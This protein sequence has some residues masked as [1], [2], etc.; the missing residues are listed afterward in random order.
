MEPLLS[1][2]ADYDPDAA[3]V[4]PRYGAEC[5]R[6]ART[7]DVDAITRISAEREGLA[8]DTIRHRIDA[9]IGGAGMGDAWC[10]FVAEID[11]EVVAFG[12]VRYLT[13]AE[14]GLP[15]SLPEG[16]HLTGV[17]VTPRFRRRGLGAALTEARL[18]WLRGRAD[19]VFY[20][21]NLANRTSIALHAAFGFEEVAR[22]FDYPRAG[23]RAGEGAAFRLALAPRAG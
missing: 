13:H 12:R 4:G 7:D 16:W 10:V 21:S 20:V 1:H 19:E 8:P 17:V 11:A 2:I 9:E 14:G 18:D 23:R 5:V 3:P 15:P 22:D 6:R